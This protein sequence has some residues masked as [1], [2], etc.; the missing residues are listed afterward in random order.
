MAAPL[1]QPT[2]GCTGKHGFPRRALAQKAA[3]RLNGRH[4]EGHASVYRCR[5]CGLF[6]VGVGRALKT[7]DRRREVAEC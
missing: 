6:H 1:V 5:S 2:A 4:I 7:K 3:D